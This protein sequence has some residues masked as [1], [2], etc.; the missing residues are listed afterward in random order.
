MHMHP[1]FWDPFPFVHPVYW[2]GFWF[3]CNSY[4]YDYGV[5]NVTVVREYVKENYNTDLVTY[6]ISGDVMFALTR[7]DGDKHYIQVFDKKDNMLTEQEIPAAYCEMAI[8]KDNGGCWLMKD[9]GADPLLFFYDT[10]EG[11]LLIYEEDR[12]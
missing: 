4:W 1:V 12:K 2:P 6:V 5:R 11:K 10:Q 9:G 8:D 7:G 3:Y